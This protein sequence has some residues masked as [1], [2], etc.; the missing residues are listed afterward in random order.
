MSK[1]ALVVDDSKTMRDMVS[2]TLSGLGFAVSAAGDGV[3]AVDVVDKEQF[4]LIVTD[5]NMPNM[6]GIELIRYL[7]EEANLRIPILV[8]T[9]E[10]GDKAK[11]MGRKAGAT[12]WLVKPFNPDTLS[13]AAR[14]VCGL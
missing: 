13:A 8:L 11:E 7:R 9:T 6:D 12:G 1:K 10:G 14:K 3:E 2:H 4:D 5:I